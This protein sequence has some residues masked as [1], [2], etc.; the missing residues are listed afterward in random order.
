MFEILIIYVLLGLLL[1]NIL[2]VWVPDAVSDHWVWVPD[3][4]FRHDAGKN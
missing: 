3:R 4:L 2:G 1:A